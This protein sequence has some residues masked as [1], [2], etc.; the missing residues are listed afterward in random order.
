MLSSQQLQMSS[1]CAQYLLISDCQL[2]CA[3]LLLL[4][5]LL[6]AGVEA[7]SIPSLQE[8]Q[9]MLSDSMAAG[10]SGRAAVHSVGERDS[11]AAAGEGD[12][13]AG[14]AA[15]RA[16]T[17]QRVVTEP[18]SV[19]HADAV[20]QIMSLLT[21]DDSS[22]ASGLPNP[23]S[24]GPLDPTAVL[25]GY[26]QAGEGAR[27]TD[28]RLTFL[29]QAVGQLEGPAAVGASFPALLG[30]LMQLGVMSSRE[31]YHTTQRVEAERWGGRMPLAGPSSLTAKAA[32]SAVELTDFH[33]WVL[34]R[35]A[36]Q[37]MPGSIAVML[38]LLTRSG[39]V[40]VP[41]PF[42][43]YLALCTSHQQTTDSSVNHP[44][45]INMR[46]SI[47]GAC[48][49]TLLH[50]HPLCRST[51][52]ALASHIP[53]EGDTAGIPPGSSVD[54]PVA[55][56]SSS[57][58]E[59]PDGVQQWG[60]MDWPKGVPRRCSWRWRGALTGGGGGVGAIRCRGGRWFQS[61]G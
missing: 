2:S 7:G 49:L 39:R 22:A 19:P 16:Q 56:T 52:R 43:Q 8:L 58:E 23:V 32:L 18:Q 31:V 3:P 1:S 6:S 47:I 11:N 34:G 38:A 29:S 40:G 25:T 20:N 48:V 41:A 50:L 30:P 24:S 27:P 33:R 57:Y 9:S 10:P 51:C 28:P 37:A 45:C 15:A 46:S 5:Y 59:T 21:G 36:A 17:L 12:V 35:G 44:C 54:E 26:L 60:I 61:A 42:V 14:R 53:Q 13:W 4:S 55:S